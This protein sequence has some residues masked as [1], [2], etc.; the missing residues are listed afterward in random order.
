MAN[1]NEGKIT[2]LHVYSDDLTRRKRRLRQLILVLC[3]KK[4]KNKMDILTIRMIQ[5]DHFP[6]DSEIEKWIGVDAYKFWYKLTTFIEAQ[7]PGVFKPEWLYGGKKQGW[8]L[9][10]KKSKSFCTLIPE[11]NQFK[12]QIVFGAKER[13]KVES[14]RENISSST[15]KAYDEAK[16]Y[17]DGKWLYLLVNSEKIEKDIEQLLTI[18]RKPKKTLS[19]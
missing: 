15:R 2:Q 1:N 9:R 4:W 11:K 5:N 3:G 13:E 8:S 18:K 14:V 10:Y 6:N 16:T 12:V 17:H 7:Y 19:A